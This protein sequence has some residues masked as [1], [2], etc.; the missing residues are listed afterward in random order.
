MIKPP[1]RLLVRLWADR[2]GNNAVEFVWVLP[3]LVFIV[4]G[5]YDIGRA[6]HYH[7][8]MTEGVRAGVRYLT[9]LADPCSAEAMQAAVGLV[10]TRSIDWSGPPL[11]P[12]W[13]ANYAAAASS[14]TF[15]VARTGCDA[16]TGTLTGSTL[17]LEVQYDYDMMNMVFTDMNMLDVTLH[18]RHQELHIGL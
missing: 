2:R 16:S 8:G 15:R 1:L 10:V 3:I 17:D 9:R 6:I 14:T 11:F 13:P 12:D 4:M 5:V 18:A 7:Q